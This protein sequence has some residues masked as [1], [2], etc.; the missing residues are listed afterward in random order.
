MPEFETRKRKTMSEQEL[1]REYHGE[2]NTPRKAPSPKGKNTKKKKSV[3]AGRENLPVSAN[4]KRME[5]ELRRKQTTAKQSKTYAG[6]ASGKA[7]KNGTSSRSSKRSSTR[8]KSSSSSGGHS[9]NRSGQRAAAKKKSGRYTL[10][11]VLIGIVAVVAL[12]ILSTTVLFN[13]RVFVVNGETVYSDEEIIEACGIE[14][15]E[16]LLKI[17]TGRAEK[18]IV[19]NLVYIESAKVGRGFPNRLTLSVEPAKAVVAFAYGGKYY[20]ISDQKRLLEISDT[21]LGCPVVKGV[22][23][24]LQPKEDKKEVTTDSNSE[25]TAAAE[26]VPTAKEG[27]T[28]ENDAEEIAAG[29]ILGDDNNNRIRLALSIVKLM[30]EN[31]LKKDYELNIADTLGVQISYDGHITMDLGTTAALDDK[32]YHASRVIEEDIGENEKCTLNLTN[33]NRVVKRPVYEN[34][35]NTAAAEPEPVTEEQT[36]ESEPEPEP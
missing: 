7:P 23:M 8:S 17:N 34:N 6:K 10:Y 19:S 35:E 33:P 29:V 20:V 28:L 32:I 25:T 5:E 36:T 11:Y 3:S 15:G 31:G 9:A 12:A 16:N 26:P 27:I 1:Y 2:G 18:S 30:T 21:P 4:R 13:I 22:Q 14:K 24:I